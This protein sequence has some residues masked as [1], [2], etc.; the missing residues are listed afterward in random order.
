[1]ESAINE[2][3]EKRDSTGNKVLVKCEGRPN[4]FQSLSFSKAL[5][6]GITKMSISKALAF[7]IS[8]DLAFGIYQN[9]ELATEKAPCGNHWSSLLHVSQIIGSES[10]LF[11]L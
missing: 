10:R 2:V 1:M 8:K 3:V 9:A 7:G 5:A 4:Q 6:F 11:E